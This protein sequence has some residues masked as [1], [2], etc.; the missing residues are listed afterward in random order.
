MK[1]QKSE[2]KKQK[3]GM[4]QISVIRFLLLATC[5]LLLATK[6]FC[7]G[8]S[9]QTVDSGDDVGDFTSI[10]LDSNNYPHISYHDNTNNSLKYAKWN[11]TAWSTTTVDTGFLGEDTSIALDSNN[12]PHISY[13]SNSD[14]LKYA[15]W[16]GTVWSTS[17]V[18]SSSLSG[19]YTSIALDSSNNPHISYY[20]AM[21][22]DLKYSSWT[23]TSWVIS[24]IESDGDVGT[25]TSIAV[26]SKNY[27]HISY[28]HST[29]G[30]L[31][32]AKWTGTA[33]STSTVV[34]GGYYSSISLDSND[35]PHISHSDNI[36]PGLRYS[37]WDGA[38]WTTDLVDTVGQV[39]F[40]TSIAVDSNNYPHISYYRSGGAGLFGLKYAKW[41]GTAWTTE[42]VDAVGDV[43]WYT[44]IALDS[45]DNPNIS[46]RDFTNSD[47]KYA[48]WVPDVVTYFIKGYAKD[49]AG[50]AINGVSI[51]LTGASQG[52]TTTNSS[53]YYEFLS[54]A[55]G[56]YTVTASKTDYT[57]SPVSISTTSLSISVSNW[58]FVGTYTAKAA[59][60]TVTQSGEVKVVGGT[61]SRGA[62]NPDK[63]ESVKVDFKGT[64]VGKFEC[65]IF[66]LTGELVH[67]ETK[68]NLSEGRFEWIPK[69]IAS[70]IYVVHIKGPGVSIH[71]KMA[72]VR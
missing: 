46:Y 10:A 40:Y 54:L 62:V 48:K 18:D 3:I 55:K 71:K 42:S 47:L 19:W 4:L 56:S 51:N 38:S 1:N 9:L 34:V 66:T 45:N 43:G 72:I 39:G 25:Y 27:P 53:G 35:Y 23:G 65:R 58:D 31:K 22:Y 57:F 7:A 13:R 12:N 60:S 20:D 16:T 37:K 24:T 59:N 49:S 17:T 44:S 41:T 11:G 61:E 2:N 68:E 64:E 52:V 5:Y 36:S 6:G 63:G 30:Q 26:D 70:G 29:N 69:N 33:W 15:K 32:Y 14:G 8:W 50:T 21:N 67:D 28:C